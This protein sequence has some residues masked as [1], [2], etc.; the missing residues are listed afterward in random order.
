M[1]KLDAHAMACHGHGY[2]AAHGMIMAFSIHICH[3]FH[4]KHDV[5]MAWSS[6]K[7]TWP[8]YGEHGHHY[9]VFQTSVTQ[10]SVSNN[11]KLGACY[12]QW[13]ICWNGS[14][15]QKN[16]IM[17]NIE[18]SL[19]KRLHFNFNSFACISHLDLFWNHYYLSKIA[20][21]SANFVLR[22]R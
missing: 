16:A 17:N 9:S 19:P 18:M 8:Y 13:G 7:I 5:T 22:K 10:P 6:R 14:L 12:F 11:T 1:V 2:H 21:N 20:D 3:S 15:S 4:M